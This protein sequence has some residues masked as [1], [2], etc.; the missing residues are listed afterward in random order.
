MFINDTISDYFS[1]ISNAQM[2]GLAH[3]TINYSKFSY[4]I[5]TSLEKEGFIKG[6]SINSN[7]KLIK[8]F[9]G[10]IK[11]ILLLSKK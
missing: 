6:F 10:T 11:M 9:L 3:T 2:I 7:K 1:R 8:V 5:L 4:N